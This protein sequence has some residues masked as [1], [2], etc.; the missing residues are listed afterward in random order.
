MA[1]QRGPIENFVQSPYYSESELCG[2]MM[3][4]SFPKYLPWHAMHFLQRSTHFSKSSF[5][6]TETAHG[7]IIWYI[8]ENGYITNTHNFHFKHFSMRQIFK[9]K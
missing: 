6:L 7:T 2:G 4:V 3:T 8:Q 9:G 1:E 5:I